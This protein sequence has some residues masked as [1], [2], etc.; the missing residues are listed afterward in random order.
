M[1]QNRNIAVDA[2]IDITKIQGLG[3]MTFGETHY[4]A[5]SGL[6]GRSWIQQRAKGQFI[7]A[8]LQAANDACVASRGD[9]IY[10]LPG[11]TETVSAAAAIALDKAGITIIGVGNGA[12]MPTITLDT[13]ISADIDIDAANIIIANVKFSANFADITAAID[14]NATDFSL[15]GCKFAET[16]TNMNALIW[17]Q[18]AAA[19]AS[20]RMTVDGCSAIALDASN[21]HFV[22]FAG[23]GD[24]HILKNNSL[25]GD[26]GTM[27]LGG[28]GI[29][30]NVRIVDNEIVN[31]ATTTDGC[32]NLAATTKGIVARNLLAGGAAVANGISAD[33]CLLAE[34]YYQLVTADLSGLLDPAN[35]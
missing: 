27:A 18:D 12:L 6:Q 22:N 20:S 15:L 13:I 26:W 9:T 7:H 25:I 19:A 10:M 35:V 4:V 28:A 24:N 3:R 8:T 31:I 33:A 1:I 29:V 21:T 17:I 23:T 14:V 5:K 2:A 32:I 16:A 34:N 11:H 30:T